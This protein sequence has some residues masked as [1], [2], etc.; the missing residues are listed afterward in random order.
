MRRSSIYRKLTEIILDHRNSSGRN[1][2]DCHDQHCNDNT[3]SLRLGRSDIHIIKLI[4]VFV[5]FVI[6]VRLVIV[7]ILR[8]V[9]PGILVTV[10]IFLFFNFFVFDVLVF[11]FKIGRFALGCGA[12]IAAFFV[13]LMI[14]NNG[15]NL[16]GIVRFQLTGRTFIC[17]F[18]RIFTVLR[19]RFIVFDGIGIVRRSAVNLTGV[20]VIT[21]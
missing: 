1:G 15:Y 7:R 11:L 4:V 12:F 21:V 2:N 16:F 14:F 3:V 6:I 19:Q 20:V 8:G 9:F 18:F 13:L 17:C 5:L 10:S